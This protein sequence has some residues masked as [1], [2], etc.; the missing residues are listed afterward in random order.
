M[1]PCGVHLK[2]WDKSGYITVLTGSKLQ[3]GKAIPTEAK[4]QLKPG[5]QQLGIENQIIVLGKIPKKYPGIVAILFPGVCGN[6][7]ITTFI[8]ILGS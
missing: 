8:L 4:A 6:L 5:T 7:S 2:R 1:L 3:W